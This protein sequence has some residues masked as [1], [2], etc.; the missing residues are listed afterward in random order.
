MN[1]L[2]AF[3]QGMV[4]HH[5]YKN[6]TGNWVFPEDVKKE[7]NKLSQISTGET[8]NEGPIESMSK[9]KKMS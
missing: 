6:E 3:T 4:C 5:T 9:S 8:V 1:L 7:K 2:I